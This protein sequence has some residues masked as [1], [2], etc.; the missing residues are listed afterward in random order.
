[1][2]SAQPL[3]QDADLT[4]AAHRLL[5]LNPQPVP[6]YRLLRDVLRLPG[7]DIELTAARSALDAVPAVR[8]LAAAQLA[9][10]SWGRFHSQDTSVRQPFATSEAAIERALALGLDVRGPLLARTA[11]YIRRH[12]RGEVTWSDRP[13]KHDDPR[14][15]PFFTRFISAGRL[16]QLDPAD[17]L[18][19]DSAAFINALLAASF[20]D[21][22]HDPDAEVRAQQALSGIATRG[23]WPL[24][25]TVY[26]AALLGAAWPLP[27][28]LEAAWVQ[29]ILDRAGGLNY[30]TPGHA[31][32]ADPP[33]LQD[34]RLS[35][36]LRA[37]ELLSVFPAWHTLAA[38]NT[39]WLWAR[40]GAD[41]LWDAGPRA[42]RYLYWPL[43]D[44]WRR[45]ENRI[46]DGSVR[47]LALLR[48]WLD[49]AP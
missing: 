11:G 9:D 41:G 3:F 21:G 30:V 5:A 8:K 48:R 17:P 19:A 27:A 46:I 1:M 38:D 20:P 26:G 4:A 34:P 14:L 7:S 6:R 23:H 39:A 42:S 24:L 18:L 12:L 16:A 32:L 15:W 10:G 13:E 47:I 25:S 40:R 22:R 43:S 35:S 31:R 29:F 33:A 36:W 2:P 37:H 45:R 49:T 44:D 28:G